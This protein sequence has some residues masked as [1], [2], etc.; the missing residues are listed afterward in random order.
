MF[1]ADDERDPQLPDVDRRFEET[2]EIEKL[3]FPVG[4][5]V[6]VDRYLGDAESRVLDLLHHL[7]TDHAAGLLQRD[8]LENGSAK[9]AEVAVDI[10]HVQAEKQL[11]RVVI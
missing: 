2:A 4:A 8:V 11:H 1:P 6:M 9:Q 10:A 3:R 5:V 7:E